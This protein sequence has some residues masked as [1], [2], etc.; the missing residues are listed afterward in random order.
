MYK[1]VTCMSVCVH[2]CVTYKYI[3]FKQQI[4][5]KGHNLFADALDINALVRTA[6]SRMHL[7]L[8]NDVYFCKTREGKQKTKSFLTL[9]PCID[10][11]LLLLLMLMMSVLYMRHRICKYYSI[12]ALHVAEE[13]CLIKKK[14]MFIHFQS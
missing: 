1:C 13:R 6:S 11:F 9:I 8:Q 12:L 10:F 7:V 14:Q 2:V 4:I 5:L 3:R